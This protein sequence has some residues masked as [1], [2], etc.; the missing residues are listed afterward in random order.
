MASGKV[1]AA[2]SLIAAVPTGLVTGLVLGPTAGLGAVTGCLAGIILTPDLDLL[3][4]Q[5]PR[6]REV[7]YT[8]AWVI[9]V[10][11]VIM[12]TVGVF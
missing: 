9:L 12:R 6:W 7:L 10:V 11:V 2:V 1:H 4:A 5:I 8:L 3:E